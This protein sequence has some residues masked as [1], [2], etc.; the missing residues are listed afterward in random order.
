MVE[1]IGVGAPD[2]CGDGFQGYGLRSLLE[3]QPACSGE[4]SGA[5]FFGAKAGSFY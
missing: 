5:A 2:L 1:Q 3:Q 4:R